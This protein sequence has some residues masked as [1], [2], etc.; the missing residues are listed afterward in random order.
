M[1][2]S[3]PK[4]EVFHRVNKLKL[5]AEIIHIGGFKAA[6]E[7]FTRTEPSPEAKENLEWLVDGLYGQMVQSIATHRAL[8]P[9]RVKEL[10]DQ[11][12]FHASE[13]QRDKLV[14]DVAY[15]EDYLASLKEQFGEDIR[16]NTRYGTDKKKEVD[17][18]SPFKFFRMLGEAM[19]E[20]DEPAADS[21]ALIH[22]DGMIVTGTTEQGLFGESGTVGSTTV[23]RALNRAR[24]LDH[25]KA[26]VLRVDSPGGSA[27]ASEIIWHA[28]RDLIAEKPF[29]VSMGNVAAS[30]GYYVA[31]GAQTIYAEPATITGSIGVIGGKLVTGD[32]WDWAGISFHVIERGENAGLST[33]LR[34]W[35]ER[36]RAIVKEDLEKIYEDFTERVKQGRGEQL[37]KKMDEIAGGRVYTGAQAVELGLVDKLGGLHDAIAAA[38]RAADIE[39]YELILLPEPLSFMDVLVRSLT[40]EPPRDR[41]VDLSLAPSIT[42]GR[43]G[44]SLT[45]M[46]LPLLKRLEPQHANVVAESLKRIELLHQE[47][48]LA[49]LP[50]VI[51]FR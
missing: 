38:A 20:E 49:V 31:C 33:T 44:G 24:R 8:E 12:L 46:L 37:Q 27:L 1:S 7:P 40:G 13:A 16:F 39:E 3:P 32:L 5:K 9:E 26:V 30:G 36:E 19:A 35:T 28:T 21:I 48:A 15:M 23:R 47:T 50:A 34:P 41:Q 25:V 2:D 18:S 4:V 42:F 6:G 11:G 45:D 29:I 22:V 10:I 51:R 17:I 43:R 14:D